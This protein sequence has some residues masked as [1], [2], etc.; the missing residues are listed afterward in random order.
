MVL[1]FY[2]IMFAISA[3]F[4]ICLF[5]LYKEKISWCYLLVCIFITI[6]N[7]GSILLFR[8]RVVEEAIVANMLTYIASAFS[9]LLVILCVSD[10]CHIKSNKLLII[11]MALFATIDLLLP[12]TIGYFDVYYKSVNLAFG[13]G[14]SYLVKEYGPLHIYHTLYIISCIVVTITSLIHTAIKQ[15][16]VSYKIIG[17]FVLIMIII[18]FTYIFE[19]LF[20]SKID[21]VPLAY[22]IGE[23]IFLILLHRIKYFNI[24]TSFTDSV[25]QGQ[26]YGLVIFDLKGRFSGAN[27]TAIEWFPELKNINID[28]NEISGDT[29]FINTLID[30]KNNGSDGDTKLFDIKDKIIKAKYLEI[31]K[32]GNNASFC[33]ELSDNTQTQRYIQLMN[34]YN[35]T[36][37]K[38][39]D[40]KTESIIKMQDDI[41]I[42]MASIVENRDIDTGGHIKRTSDCVKVFVDYLM[43]KN[44]CEQLDEDYARC[45]IKAA[46]LHD[47]GKV[48]INDSVLNKKAYYK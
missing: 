23:F 26:N 45:I 1:G 15:K 32:K 29:E 42:S 46:P 3:I 13:Y 31:R 10:L 19:R 14:Y 37:K 43:S 38:E 12:L 41:I 20:K 28:K 30:W 36:L 44:K 16:N 11:L 17:V 4:T 24:S 5:V 25:N 6:S 22:C 27:D 39:V 2:W 34:S 48:G 40:L 8:S 9:P 7:L 18:S 33:I 21:F 35:D 47:F